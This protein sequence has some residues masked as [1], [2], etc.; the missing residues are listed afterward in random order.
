MENNE[1]I[2]KEF[3]SAFHL[4]AIPNVR[5]DIHVLKEVVHYKD[6]R[7]VPE[8]RIIENFKRPFWVT[9]EHYQ[10]HKEK[11]ECEALDR[12]N[13]FEATES[14]LA[15]A[16]LT[17]LGSKYNGKTNLRDAL[18]SPYVYGLNI[19]AA[20][21]IK[22]YYTKKYPDVSTPYTVC[23]LDT[24]VDVDTDELLILSVCMGN[25][26]YVS[27]KDR[28]GEGR[29]D[30]EKTLKYLYDKY[31]PDCELKSNMNVVFE[32]FDSELQMILNTFKRVHEW[33]PDFLAI[34]N[35]SYDMEVLLRVLEAHNVDPKDV[36]SDPSLPEE[37]REFKFV[38]GPIQKVTESGVLKPLEP[39]EQW[40]YVDC[41]ASFY[42]IDAMSAYNYVRVGGKQVA[43]GYSLDSILGFELG[44]E[45]QKLK[46]KDEYSEHLTGVDWHKYM[47]NKKP[48]EYIIYNCWDV[49]SMLLLDKKTNDLAIAL[50]LLSGPSEFKI[51]N[52]G[53]KKL[54]NE[55]HFFY[56]DR[57]LVL[58]TKGNEVDDDK[59]LG[60]SD[61]IVL[62]PNFYIGINELPATSESV[63][64]RYPDVGL[65]NNIRRFI[66]DADKLFIKFNA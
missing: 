2:A 37:Y 44:K 43:T 1:I 36:F 49:M 35:I 45:Y 10:N 32:L 12:V 30:V 5:K 23:A 14:N 25:N 40:H 19:S 28:M 8:L 3:R 9:K 48:L 39:R 31:I 47:A 52:S 63:N 13:Q 21:M 22:H 26:L 15:R 34:W 55:L 58:G 50:P 17:R 16:V 57:G 56:L 65:T 7:I 59:L 42:W 61:W 53:P 46:Y 6:G 24:E 66:Y 18:P 60:L 64:E 54:V 51:F 11:K 4:S 38:K 29:T 20:T 62:L 33:K 41:P 27:I